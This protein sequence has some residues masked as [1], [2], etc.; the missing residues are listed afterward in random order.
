MKILVLGHKGML[1][2]EAAKF[3]GNIHDVM[4]LGERITRSN[5]KH[6]A[7]DLV[8]KNPDVIINCLGQIKQK[9]SDPEEMLCVNGEFPKEI[10]R[11]LSSEQVLVQPSTDCVFSGKKGRYKVDD[12]PD[13]VDAYGFSKLVS[14]EVNPEKSL[15][16]RTSVIGMESETNVSLLSWFLSRERE[17]FG[18]TNHFWSGITSLEWCKSVNSLMNSN[19]RGLHHIATTRISKYDLLTCV[20]SVFSHPVEII[21]IQ[22]KECID[23]SLDDSKLE[24]P[25]IFDQLQ[26]I[27]DRS[28]A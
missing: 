6:L 7:E 3:F 27:K 21:P 18:Y 19:E 8:S 1:G 23:R 10:S 28:C 20:G 17:V 25:C 5:Y 13:P 14:E 16:I 24:V 9:Y 26:E 22:E 2:R 12:I 4:T 15:V 11:L